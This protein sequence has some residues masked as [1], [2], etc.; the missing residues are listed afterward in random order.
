MPFGDIL[1]EANEITLKT[2]DNIK[3]RVPE[4]ILQKIGLKI[5]G[6][7]HIGMRLRAKTIFSLLELRENNMILD[8]GCGVGLYSLTLAQKGYKVHGID[9]DEDKIN[10]ANKLAQSL[11]IEN[12]SFNTADICKLTI[13]D[14]TYDRIIC[15]DV[16]EHIHND[17]AAISELIRVLKNEGY[18]I[19]SVPS[20]LTLLKKMKDD[21]D[22]A[23]HGYSKDQLIT[24][25][26]RNGLEVKECISYCKA[27]GLLAWK[28][29]RKCFGFKVL[30]AITFY[31]LYFLAMLDFLTLKGDKTLGY[32]VKAKKKDNK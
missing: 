22:H 12:I 17:N 16:I 21:F 30:T 3:V 15:S 1:S 11:C 4:S 27:F 14:E 9:A 2:A 13:N 23:R 5:F 25:L 18:L 26:E 19:L 29:N 6:V 20:D 24:L 8:A 31:P 28:L 32:V 10:N 7:P